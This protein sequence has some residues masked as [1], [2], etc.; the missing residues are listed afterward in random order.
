MRIGVYFGSFSPVHLGH[1]NI[2]RACLD[3]KLLDKV[4]VV[5]TGNYWDKHDLLDIKDRITMWKFFESDNLIIDEKHN[6]IPKTYQLIR[7]LKS[8]NPEDTFYLLLGADSLLRFNEWVSYKELLTYPFII[9]RRDEN[10]DEEIKTIM[11]NFCKT[12][13]Q[14]L[15]IPLQKISSSYIRD[16]LDDFNKL[17]GLLDKRVYDYLQSL[18]KAH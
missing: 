10:G 1:V 14:I 18:K 3:Q 4:L 5:P 9:V 11:K 12:D 15:D 6:D 7:Q 16:N 17:N 2:A 13:Y 8:E